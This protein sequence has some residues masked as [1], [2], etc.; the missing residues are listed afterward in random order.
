MDVDCD[1]ISDPVAM[2]DVVRDRVVAD[3]Q[4]KDAE[5][6]ADEALRKERLQHVYDVLHRALTQRNL[7]HTNQQTNEEGR[8]TVVSVT[9]VFQVT[10]LMSL[11]TVLGPGIHPPSRWT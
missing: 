6:K 9:M 1:V 7:I 2:F 11:S 5:K 4:A 10:G 3:H 8:V